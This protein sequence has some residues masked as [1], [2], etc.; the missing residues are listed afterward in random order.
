MNRKCFPEVVDVRDTACALDVVE[1]S[2]DVCAS[3]LILD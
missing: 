2:L 1:H 3:V